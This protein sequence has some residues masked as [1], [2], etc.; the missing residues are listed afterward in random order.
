MQVHLVP[1]ESQ[2]PRVCL[3][4]RLPPATSLFVTASPRRCPAARWGRPSCGTATVCCTSRATRNLTTRTLV[5]VLLHSLVG[6][7]GGLWYLS[8]RVSNSQTTRSW[9][10]IS[11]AGVVAGEFSS[12]G[13]TLC[14][15]SYFKYLFP[16]PTPTLRATAVACN[17]RPCVVKCRWQVTAKHAY[18]LSV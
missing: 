3:A 5:S 14:A 15:D 17:K 4:P 1:R 7:W 18:T 11:L 9:G 8:G 6:G 16:P 13:S 10:L 2:A 12:P